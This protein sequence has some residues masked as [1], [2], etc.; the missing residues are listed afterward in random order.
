MRQRNTLL[1]SKE[2]QRS[3]VTHYMILRPRNQPASTAVLAAV[4]SLSVWHYVNV[5]T[6]ITNTPASTARQLPSANLLPDGR[7][8]LIG[9]V[10]STGFVSSAEFFNPTNATWTPANPLSTARQAHTGNFLPNG[11]ILIAGG[12]NF[13]AGGPLDS[14]E[15]YDPAG[16]VTPA[17]TM[18][19]RRTGHTATLLTNGMVLVAGGTYD[20]SSHATNSVDLYNPTNGNWTPSSP[21][22]VARTAHTA[23]LLPD[24]TVLVAGGRY[25]IGGSVFLSSVEIYNPATGTWNFTNSLKTARAQ[26]AA[27]SLPGGKVLVAGGNG[28][29]A[30]TATAETYDPATGTWKSVGSMSAARYIHTATLLLSGKVLVAGGLGAGPLA[31]GEL[32]DPVGENWSPTGPLNTP[33]YAHRAILLPSGKVLIACGVG[34]TSGTY[35]S[36]TELFVPPVPP[37]TIVLTHPTKLPNGTFLFAFTNAAGATFTALATTNLTLPRTNWTTLGA[38]TEVSPGSFQFSDSQA[39]TNPQRFYSVKAN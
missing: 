31:N 13:N 38:V 22:N 9:G 24:G 36:S 26:H 19:C 25:Y 28:S 8:L 27:T 30:D 2:R 11:K 21:M 23:T 33:R 29:S 18:S 7:V 10:N 16:G 39:A 1:R 17:G 4:L 15:L 20:T 5:Q 35:L 14:A 12:F 34:Y 37:T 32:Y 6:F 3:A